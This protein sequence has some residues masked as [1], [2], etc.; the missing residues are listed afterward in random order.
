MSGFFLRLKKV[1]K[2]PEPALLR[3]FNAF[4]EYGMIPP[5]LKLVVVE[6][7]CMPTT[8]INLNNVPAYTCS[9]LDGSKDQVVVAKFPV[10]VTIASFYNT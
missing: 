7:G 8:S 5:V 10:C 3:S 4:D 9:L 2:F 6:F 1:K